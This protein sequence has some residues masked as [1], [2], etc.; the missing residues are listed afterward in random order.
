MLTELHIYFQTKEFP[1]EVDI[2]HKDIIT[3][4]RLQFL[5]KYDGGKRME[6]ALGCP[7]KEWNDGLYI[8]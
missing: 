6:N 2:L 1:K 3:F 5:D 4:W 7:P 8:F